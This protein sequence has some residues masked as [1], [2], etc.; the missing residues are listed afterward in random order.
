[1][2]VQNRRLFAARWRAS[3]AR[4]DELWERAGLSLLGY[5]PRPPDNVDPDEPDYPHDCVV[6]EPVLH[7][8][9]EP[10]QQRWVI[11]VPDLPTRWPQLDGFGAEVA[12]AL[13]ERGIAAV[14]RRASGRNRTPAYL[15]D[16]LVTMRGV[17]PIG[18]V[19]GRPCILVTTPFG[20]APG[21]GEAE[22]FDARLEDPLDDAD[23]LAARLVDTL[24]GIAAGTAGGLGDGTGS[25]EH[26][27]DTRTVE[28]GQPGQETDDERQTGVAG[29]AAGPAGAN[30]AGDGP[31][32]LSEALGGLG[33][34]QPR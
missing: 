25:G 1:V 11:E 15:D 32:G 3:T 5:R 29:P 9:L 33:D 17:R 31:R 16:V 20:R 12:A 23:A 4:G 27:D 18:P 30:G 6:L 7:A 28:A 26:G 34:L 19:S 22:R 8:V 13:E 21:V 2:S 10:G 24:A 14:S